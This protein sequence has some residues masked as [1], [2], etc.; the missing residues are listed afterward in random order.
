MKNLTKQQHF[1]IK[2]PVRSTDKKPICHTCKSSIEDLTYRFLIVK[3]NQ[4]NL[5]L[6]SFHYFFPCWDVHYVC[7]NLGKYEIF[8]AGFRCDKS[9]LKNPK[10]VNNLRKNPNLWDLEII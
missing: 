3:D 10:S 4:R 5:E 7:E 6:L 2:T 9:I 1:S 8:K